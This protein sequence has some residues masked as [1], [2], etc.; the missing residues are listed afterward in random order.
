M[1]VE[2]IFLPTCWVT[3]LGPRGPRGGVT[4]SGPAVASSGSGAHP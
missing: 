2:I 3:P 4:G 1:L